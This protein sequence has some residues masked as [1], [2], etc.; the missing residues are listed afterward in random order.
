M[1][2]IDIKSVIFLAMAVVPSGCSL[3]QNSGSGNG[4]VIT[5]DTGWSIRQA[6]RAVEKANGLE[7]GSLTAPP[8][9]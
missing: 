9:K 8:I 5:H 2:N 4:G 6:Q 3:P 7:P 1:K